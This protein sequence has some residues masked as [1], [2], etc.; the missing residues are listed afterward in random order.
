MAL[1]GDTF[2]VER[3]FDFGDSA[4]VDN[5]YYISTFRTE[6]LVSPI[7]HCWRSQLCQ[8]PVLDSGGQLLTTFLATGGTDNQVLTRT[9]TS[10]AWEDTAAVIT[11]FLGLD[12][13]PA[14]FGSV[15]QAVR[16]A[17]GG[18]ALEF[19]TPTSGGA[20]TFL[21]LTDTPSALGTTG[22]VVTVNAGGTALE[23][24]LTHRVAQAP[25]TLRPSL[26]PPTAGYR[27]ARRLALLH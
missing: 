12:D 4:V 21:G 2:T 10:M 7:N 17:T 20:T 27:A 9:G 23:F 24:A 6:Q 8:Y 3:G 18:T 16:V 25:A 5:I 13:T 1:G 26:Q 19:Y 14:A 11:T 22:Q 15:G